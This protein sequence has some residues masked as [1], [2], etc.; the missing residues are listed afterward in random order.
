[1]TFA[2][3]MQDVVFSYERGAREWRFDL[4]VPRGAR[5][6][7][8]GASGSGKSTLL[9][10]VAGHVEPH[11]GT[12]TIDGID[13]TRRRPGRRP[14][15]QVFQD[16]NLFAHLDVLTN[17]ALGVAPDGRIDRAVRERSQA[18]LAQVGLEGFGAR[19]PGELSGGER[20]RA[21]LARAV[22]R[23]EPLL[24]LDEAF[25]ALGPALA[26]EMGELVVSI[27]EQRVATL[28][29]I[30]HEP[31]EAKRL[32]THMAFIHA[33]HVEVFG[34]VEAIAAAPPPSLQRYLGG[35]SLL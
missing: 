23:D 1:M 13:V 6:A 7:L 25:G 27:A 31:E 3:E 9:D 28:V 20:G 19:Y 8:L 24:L 32:A 17:V 22:L 29:F 35:E 34:P 21:A 5:C 12:V 26:R 16:H 2:L 4:A 18:A 33:D 11:A 14:V 15:S 30:T 10:L